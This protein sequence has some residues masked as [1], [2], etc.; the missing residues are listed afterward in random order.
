MRPATRIAFDEAAPA[1]GDLTR[2]ER[3]KQE[4][5]ARLLD[6]A[7]E[8]FMARGYDAVSTAEIAAAADVGAGTFYLHFED[9]RTIF[10]AIGRRAVEEILSRWRRRLN[11]ALS[12]AEMVTAMIRGA[13]EF[14]A[15][16]PRRTRLLLEDGPPIEAQGYLKLTQS[17]AAALGEAR[18]GAAP[19][20][21]PQTLAHLVVALAFQLG[22]VTLA[23]DEGDAT[24][25]AQSMYRLIARALG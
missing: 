12:A 19:I 24:R 16:S 1:P 13:A 14:W 11:P 4:T 23:G 17:V 2:T 8:S 21:E 20:A 25:L 18:A 9:K 3:R 10:K 5:C 7:L 15:E 22:R 6:A